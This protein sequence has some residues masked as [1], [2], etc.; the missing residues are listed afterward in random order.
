MSPEYQKLK[1]PYE[2]PTATIRKGL[3]DSVKTGD[4]FLGYLVDVL[5]GKIEGDLKELKKIF[6]ELI[7]CGAMTVRSSTNCNKLNPL[8]HFGDK[9][10]LK[11]KEMGVQ[12]ALVESIYEDAVLVGSKEAPVVITYNPKDKQWKIYLYDNE[13]IDND[14]LHKLIDNLNKEES[15]QNG[16]SWTSFNHGSCN[17][18]QSPSETKLP[19]DGILETF[20]KILQEK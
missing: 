4:E 8:A 16:S 12:V 15:S 17:V 5:E 11:W 3:N 7:A 18:I 1:T 2:P 6:D 14:N 10:V 20:T 19:S 13:Q 9:W